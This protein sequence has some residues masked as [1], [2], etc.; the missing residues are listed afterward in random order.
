V[1]EAVTDYAWDMLDDIFLGLCVT[2]VIV[3][4]LLKRNWR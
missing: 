4:W 1:E 2:V 3:V